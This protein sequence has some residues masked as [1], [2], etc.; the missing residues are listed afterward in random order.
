MKKE[1]ILFFKPDEN[2]SFSKE[3]YNKLRKN[4]S[5]III[6]K[7]NFK[8]STNYSFNKKYLNDI[9]KNYNKIGIKLDINKIYKIDAFLKKVSLNKKKI[10]ISPYFLSGIILD[11][12]IIFYEISKKYKIQ[13]LRPELSF[14]KNRYILSKNIFKNSYNLK[15]KTYFSK[16]KLESFK[17]NYTKSIQDFSEKNYKKKLNL[18]FYEILKKILEFFFKIKFRNASQN[19]AIVV[20][21]NNNRLQALSKKIYFKKTLSSILKKTNL[22]LIFL[23]HPNTGL[24]KFFLKTIKDK[25][26]I[27][28]NERILFSY[29]PKNLSKLIKE[30]KFI[31]HL[32]SSLSA[33]SLILNKK[34]LCLTTNILYIRYLKNIVLNFKTKNLRALEKKI[35]DKEIL[36]IDNFLINLLSNSVNSKGEFKL[37]VNKNS[38]TSDLKTFVQDKYDKKIILNLLNAI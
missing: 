36:E 8:Y 26:Y 10:F 38:Y 23:I 34:I 14:I 9:F 20:L 16:K 12:E 7:E 21:N 5:K 27:L 4:F 15:K 33:Q 18:N 11:D 29:R 19:Y 17:T 30:S 31:I 35:N 13:F 1:L 37:F 3:D 2:F 32:S 24:L 22:N 28:K 6:Y 25:K